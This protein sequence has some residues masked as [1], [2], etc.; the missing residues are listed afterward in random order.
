[1]LETISGQERFSWQN[2]LWGYRCQQTYMGKRR[3]PRVGAVTTG[4]KYS[5]YVSFTSRYSGGHTSS[6]SA[7]KLTRSTIWSF[8][9]FSLGGSG[10]RRS[11][12]IWKRVVVTLSINTSIIGGIELMS[13]S[14]GKKWSKYRPMCD[15][16]WAAARSWGVVQAVAESPSLVSF[17]GIVERMSYSSKMS[18]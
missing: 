1:M 8:W 18:H 2:S 14:V 13:I 7:E 3:H 16:I 15:L 10:S 12:L 5:L 4:G 17:S 6:G 9:C 11:Y